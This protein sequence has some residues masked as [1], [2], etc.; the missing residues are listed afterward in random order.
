MNSSVAVLICTMNRADDL[1]R[2]L[3][4]LHAC[5]PRP[6]QIV[7]SDDSPADRRESAAV[8]GEFPDVVYVIG[9]RR[10]LAANRNAALRVANADWIHFIDDDVIVPSDLYG[11]F[12]SV[13]QRRP[14][15]L[16]S[17]SEHRY[18]SADAAPVRVEP[19][20]AGFW[21]HLG[22][23]PGAANCVVINAAF[24]PA[25]LFKRAQFDEFLKY[26]CEESDI[27]CHAIALGYELVYEPSLSVSHYPSSVNRSLYATWT[28]ASQTYA[29]LKRQWC[30]RRSSI[31]TI[32]YAFIATPRLILFHA[33]RGGWTGLRA[34]L[35]QASRGTWHFLRQLNCQSIRNG[36]ETR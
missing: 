11:C 28:I 1:R 14:V 17:G 20:Y 15:S 12:A 18:E 22:P 30:Y 8:C 33:R 6:S 3:L 21:A 2:A 29:G 27:T 9:P 5:E 34:S 26:G 4:A 19:P 31:R 13:A 36:I 7:V 10:G 25:G 35:V 23:R 32:G 24:F 16:I